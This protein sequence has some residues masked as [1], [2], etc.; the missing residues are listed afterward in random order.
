MADSGAGS[1]IETF[2]NSE[3]IFAIYK[4]FA[5]KFTERTSIKVLENKCENKAS[6]WTDFKNSF[7]GLTGMK[8]MIFHFYN[9]FCSGHFLIIFPKVKDQK[10]TGAKKVVKTKNHIFHARQPR[11]GIFEIRS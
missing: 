6:L 1:T 11:E 7:A 10:M 3:L 2:R 5:L 9:F 4:N 8:N